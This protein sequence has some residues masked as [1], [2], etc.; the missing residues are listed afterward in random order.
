M[1]CFTLEGLGMTDL[2]LLKHWFYTLKSDLSIGPCCN[3]QLCIGPR[4]NDHVQQ[5]QTDSE[6]MVK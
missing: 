5:V 4:Q 1:R 2:E 6:S 3:D